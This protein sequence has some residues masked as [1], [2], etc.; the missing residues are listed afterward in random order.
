MA[1]IGL[2]WVLQNPAVAT[3]IVSATKEHHLDDAGKSAVDRDHSKPLSCVLRGLQTRGDRLRIDC[4]HQQH[5]G[6]RE[7]ADA[8]RD[9]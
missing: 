8:T 9:A 4:R 1:T 2:V 7:T 6:S 5:L 3:P